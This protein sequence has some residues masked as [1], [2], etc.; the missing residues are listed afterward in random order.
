MRP[1]RPRLSLLNTT[2]AQLA[3]NVNHVLTACFRE[4]YGVGDSSASPPS[5]LLLTSPLAATEEVAN[6][7][8]AGLAPLKI[9]MPSVLNAIGADRDQIEE[10][11]AEAEK[12][13]AEQKTRE[14]REKDG[15]VDGNKVRLDLEVKQADANTEKTRAETA[16]LKKPQPAPK[17]SGE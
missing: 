4:I 1:S 7:F 13:Q 6:L 17:A 5:L 10:A 11:L 9:A 12:Q 2:V 3:R 15:E 16:N 8:G 14:D